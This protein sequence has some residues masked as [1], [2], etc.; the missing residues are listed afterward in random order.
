MTTVLKEINA[1]IKVAEG[2]EDDRMAEL[3]LSLLNTMK[4]ALLRKV[5]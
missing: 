3:N 2:K 4:Q 1:A 5:R